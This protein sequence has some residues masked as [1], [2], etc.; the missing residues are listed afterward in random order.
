MPATYA[1]R[2][3]LVLVTPEGA[4]APLLETAMTIARQF[5]S[6]LDV[7]YLD[8]DPRAVVPA[9]GEGLSAAMMDQMIDTL[10]KAAVERRERA[11]ANYQRLCKGDGKIQSRW[12]ETTDSANGVAHA[13]R[14]ADLILAARPVGD[15]EAPLEATLDSALFDTGCPVLV[16]PPEATLS[17]GKHALIAWNGSIQSARAVAAALPFLRQAG[18]VT[19]AVAEDA[20][21]ETTA[22]ELALMLGRHG[23]TTHVLRLGDKDGG[24]VA[25]S[26]EAECAQMG[27][28]LLVMGA[29]GHSRLREMILGGV[30]RRVLHHARIPVLMCH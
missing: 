21:K 20:D 3:L 8:M 4:S 17:V 10:E 28:D 12:R 25:D 22:S 23:V 16:T 18:R 26:L 13:G 29:Y 19:I 11:K 5:E 7:L 27:A 30:T 15:A 9:V 2:T 6:H 14:V 1:Y 24:N